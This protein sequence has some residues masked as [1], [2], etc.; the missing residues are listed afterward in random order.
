M[1][2]PPLFPVQP[3]GRGVRANLEAAPGRVPGFRLP[4]AARP[5]SPPPRHPQDQR[6]VV[7]VDAGMVDVR[8]RR[9]EPADVVKGECA[10]KTG[11]ITSR[12]RSRSR[13]GRSMTPPCGNAA[14]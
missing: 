5:A 8:L 7:R 9:R 14:V 1:R 13:N 2:A 11:A 6:I 3:L 4:R 10:G 12:S